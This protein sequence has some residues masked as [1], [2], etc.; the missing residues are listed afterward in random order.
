M[1]PVAEQEFIDSLPI[2]R[3]LRRKKDMGECPICLCILI[4]KIDTECGHEYHEICLLE[5]Q[6]ISLTCPL[7]RRH[8]GKVTLQ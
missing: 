2:I 8:L 6:K 4:K 7:C 3:R 5:W 1:D